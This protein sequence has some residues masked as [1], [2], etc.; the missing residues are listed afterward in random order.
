MQFVKGPDFPTGGL[1]YTGPEFNS[2]YT[3]GKGSFVVRGKAEISEDKSGKHTI[4]ITEIPY[5]VQKSTLLE[6]FA[7]LVELKLIDNVKDIRD[8]SDKDGMRVVVELK[9]TAFPK[10]VLNALYKYTDLQKSF[11][12]NMLALV[13]GIHPQVLGLTEMLGLFI[14]H[15]L[16]VITKR[17]EYDLAR[18]KERAHIL[19]GLHIC[20]SK[21]DAVIKVIK[22]SKDREQAQANLM[23]N[24]KLSELQARAVLEMRLQQ[25]AQ[26]E[27]EKIEVELEEKRKLIKELETLLKS[28]KKL[29]ELVKKEAL[30][31]GQ[32]YE[33]ILRAYYPKSRLVQREK[34]CRQLM[35][36]AIVRSS[37]ELQKPHR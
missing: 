19:E 9:P 1:I 30:E 13:D 10:K 24:F 26:L 7:K 21:I 20:L 14:K 6:R 29:R 22:Q 28:P 16:E 17:S 35:L 27:Q 37:Q 25:L 4:I 12:L 36:M 2:I 33:E 32:K 18:A 15:R 31:A 11:H 5:Q 23:K 34:I 8:E 3:Q